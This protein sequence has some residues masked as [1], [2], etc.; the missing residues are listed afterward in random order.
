MMETLLITAAG[1]LIGFYLLAP[2]VLKRSMRFNRFPTLREVQLSEAPIPVEFRAHGLSLHPQLERL[3]FEAGPLIVTDDMTPGVLAYEAKYLRR[4]D[5]T[6]ASALGTFATRGGLKLKKCSL[7]FISTYPTG[8][9][10]TNNSPY[11]WCA[12]PKGGSMTVQ[13]PW[14]SSADAL[15]ELHAEACKRYG[16]GIAQRDV[17][18]GWAH[19]TMRQSIEEFVTGNVAANVMREAGSGLL[20]LTWKGAWRLSYSLLPPGVWLVR[21]RTHTQARELLRRMPVR[22]HEHA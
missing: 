7:D 21:W 8:Q 11:I 19:R 14:I 16:T 9:I 18:E 13:A 10:I 3:G 22:L 15:L 20:A 5:G 6:Q 12:P 4:T 1:L 17:A 2:V